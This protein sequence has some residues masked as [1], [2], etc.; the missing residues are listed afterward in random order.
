MIEIFKRVAVAPVPVATQKVQDAAEAVSRL[1]A[2]RDQAAAVFDRAQSAYEETV[3]L[4]AELGPGDT[5]ADLTKKRHAVDQ[6]ERLLVESDM[7]LQGAKKRHDAAQ[8]AER[9]AAKARAW[10]IASTAIEQRSKAAAALQKRAEA[11]A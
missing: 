4:A 7:A 8:T 10:E 2:A 5:A 11:Y 3:L 1:Q 6:A 9:Q